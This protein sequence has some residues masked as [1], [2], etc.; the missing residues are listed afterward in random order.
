VFPR[1]PVSRTHKL[2][3]QATLM[4]V[5]PRPLY[6]MA[7]YRWDVTAAVALFVQALLVGTVGM[8]VLE[9]WLLTD[10]LYFSF[11]TICGIGER[12]P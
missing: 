7:A 8:A 11:V 12:M 10:S 1:V 5:L 9:A 2:C 6:D 3:V 4:E